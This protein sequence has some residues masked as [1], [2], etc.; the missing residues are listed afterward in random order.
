ML[1]VVAIIVVATTSELVSENRTQ[2]V[3][4]PHEMW[5]DNCRGPM[6]NLI[7]HLELVTFFYFKNFPNKFLIRFI[8]LIKKNL[9]IQLG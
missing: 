7:I 6:V 4:L 1:V 3:E 8:V 9:S 2:N 5:C